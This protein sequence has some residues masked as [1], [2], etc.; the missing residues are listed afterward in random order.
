MARKISLT[1]IILVVGFAGCSKSADLPRTNGSPVAATTPNGPASAITPA[2]ASSTTKAK[3]DACSLLSSADIQAVQGE[4]V[5]ETKPSG[6]AAGGLNIS[7]CFYSL[8]TFTNSISLLVAQ[9][10]EG[11]GA[12]DPKDFFREH[13]ERDEARDTDKDKNRHEEKDRDRRKSGE[14][15]EEGGPPPEKVSGLGDEAYWTGTRV[16][17]ALYVLKGDSYLRISIGGPADQPTKLKKS[18]TL[19]AKALAHL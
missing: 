12:S 17:G 8:P 11:A 9:K 16:G 13:F 5:K 2:T 18:K 4:A 14:E 7:Q 1:L 6:Q 15:E 10:G 19:A 3:I